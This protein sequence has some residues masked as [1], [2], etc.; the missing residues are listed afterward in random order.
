MGWRSGEVDAVVVGAGA[1]GIG[2]ARRLVASGLAVELLEARDRVGGRAWT[3]DLGGHPADMG[4]GWLHSADRNPWTAIAGEL[5]LAIDRRLPDWGFGFAAERQLTAADV[6]ARDAAFERFWSAVE[7][8]AEHDCSLAQALPGDDPWLGAFAAVTSYIS[9]AGPEALSLL[10]LARYEDSG[11]NWRVV[12]GYGR[13]MQLHAAGLPVTLRAPV[14]AIDWGRK[15]VRVATDRGELRCRAVVVTVPASLL[16]A[17]AIRF[18]PAL[19]PAT[20]AAAAG[21]P[22]GDVLKLYLGV[23]GDPFG[24]GADR[25]VV[26][27]P[28]RADT[29]IYHL[30]PLGR[31]LVECY[32]GGSLARELERAGTGA[33]AEFALHELA[34]LFGAD[35]R[36]R[37]RPLQASTWASD[38]WSRG[39]YSF[40]RP[41]A[42]EGRAVLAAPVAGR[43][44]IAGEACS[45]G[46]YSTAHGAL[47]TG[48]AAA[49]LVVR[50]L[51][52]GG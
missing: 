38:P 9:G 32:W 17:E 3:L 49:E 37:L 2:A 23:E 20:L 42:A 11:L 8:P 33:A 45:R 1:A 7:A 34:G 18:T 48:L 28:R 46:A 25:Q 10:D 22:L 27:A 40:A 4:C 16:T 43:L 39:A 29:A 15:L 13:L 14:K 6:A 31:P 44:F 12:A 36:R 19:P 30:Q 26:G 50:E 51:R 52:G 24:A 35:V 41:G 47:L 21:L 5:G